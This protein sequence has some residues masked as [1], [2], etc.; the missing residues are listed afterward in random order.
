[1][2]RHQGCYRYILSFYVST[3]LLSFDLQADSTTVPENHN[4]TVNHAIEEGWVEKQIAPPTQWVESIFS[5][6]TQW[7]ESEIQRQ[8]DTQ[9][10][11]SAVTP[12]SHHLISVQQA[13]N[14]VL[15]K[16]QGKILRSQFKT[17]PPPYYKIKILSDK[18]TVSIVN[19]NAFSGEF[20]TPSN[21]KIK[22]EEAKP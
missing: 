9:A 15:G 10:I 2:N 6:F 7:M 22:A 18:G 8:P 11:P 5:P 12:P 16:Y 19:V 17:G 4:S 21:I 3:L 13:I 20:F 14:S 1:M